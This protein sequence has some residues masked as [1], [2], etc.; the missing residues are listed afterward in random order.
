M[1]KF[2]KEI[3]EAQK[4]AD[5]WEKRSQ[6]DETFFIAMKKNGVKWEKDEVGQ[7]EALVKA[8]DPTAQNRIDGCR[9]WL[10]DYQK[11]CADRYDKHAEFVRGAPRDGVAGICAKL[12]LAKGSEEYK[13][14][15]EALTKVLM[16]HTKQFKATEAA[17]Q[18]DLKPRI[19]LLFSKLDTLEKLA[20]GAEK[21]VT[22]YGKQ[23]AADVTK[24]KSM[25]ETAI[26][27]LKVDPAIQAIG[28][29]AKDKNGWLSGSEK[30]RAD[31]YSVYLERVSNIPKLK[32]LSEKNYNR[33]LKSVP[34]E[35]RDKIMFARP[36]KALEIAKQ[37][38]DKELD[39]ALL[40]FKN[41]KATFE[42]NYPELV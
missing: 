28:N 24:Y 9:K 2:D 36:L 27:S 20:S 40:V 41:A 13:A 31:A 11:T 29:M 14:V 8:K 12:K 25:M 26:G 32:A 19:E 22:A 34:Q 33:I 35:V 6:D 10:A 7:I 16:T 21:E 30:A 1:G 4:I 17:W 37:G 3:K 18:R 42:K 39:K 23:F 15:S 38:Y 5:S